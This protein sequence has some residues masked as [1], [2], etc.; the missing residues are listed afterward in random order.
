[1]ESGLS[2]RRIA[3]QDGQLARKPRLGPGCPG[4]IDELLSRQPLCPWC[5]VGL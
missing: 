3:A 5:P 4:N 1:M 2:I